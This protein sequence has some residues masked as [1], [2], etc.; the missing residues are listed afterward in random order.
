M[1]FYAAVIGMLCVTFLIT[2]CTYQT[3][4]CRAEA[5]KAGVKVE[6][7]KTLCHMG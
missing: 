7:I 3:A 2:Q 4:S 1:L 6:E 5:V